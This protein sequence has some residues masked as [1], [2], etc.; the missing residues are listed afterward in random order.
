[1]VLERLLWG[2][3][4]HGAHH[5]VEDASRR[6]ESGLRLGRGRVEALGGTPNNLDPT[7]K[8]T[9]DSRALGHRMS[10]MERSSIGGDIRWLQID[11]TDPEELAKFWAEVLELDPDRSSSPPAFRCLL[12]KDGGP[13]LCFQRV[14]EPKTVKNRVHFDVVVSDLEGATVRI[15]QLGGTTRSDA[16]DFRE[17][18]W[19]WRIMADPEGNEF[20]LVPERLS[21]G[22]I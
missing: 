22:A 20:C 3:D 21:S 6:L 14:P 19:R 1:L 15:E 12:G 7:V 9:S 8:S 4:L 2:P 5:V 10:P 17:N 18:G 16:P 13:G 11:C